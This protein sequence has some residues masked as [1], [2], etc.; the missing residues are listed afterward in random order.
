[1]SFTLKT[2]RVT[3][4]SVVMLVLI[5]TIVL[6]LFS[7]QQ[8]N[9]IEQ[10][11]FETA[12]KQILLLIK[13]R[14][15]IYKQ[16][17]LGGAGLFYGSD[18]VT[19]QD[20][21]SY[22]EE[23]NIDLLFPGIQGMGFSRVIK[24]EELEEH[25]KKIRAEGF[26]SYTIIPQGKRDLYTSIIYLE[27]FNS[28]NQRA[29]GFDMF[30]EPVRQE[31]MRRAI[32]T[33]E[34]SMSRKVR[35]LQE[36]GV[37]E[38]SGFLIYVPVYNKK[39]PLN[40]KEEKMQAIQG[41]VYAPFRSKDLMTGIA[42]NMVAD[43]D[44]EIYDN[45]I[46]DKSTLLFDS[47]AKHYEQEGDLKYTHI[48]EIGGR[49][50]TIQFTAMSSFHEQISNLTSWVILV[51]GIL[52]SIFFFSLLNSFIIMEIRQQQNL[53]ELQTISLRKNLALQTG[54]IGIWEWIYDSDTLVWDDMMYHIY[55]IT[56]KKTTL[57][58]YVWS[59]AIDVNE[60]H[61]VE[62][63]LVHARKHN[64]E[65]NT[66]FW[67]TT[68]TGKRKYIQSV[69]INEYNTHGNAYR[70]VGVNID[71]TKQKEFEIELLQAKE[72]A[73]LANRSKS[74]FVANMSHEIR[75]PMNG[76]IGLIRLVLDT[77]LKP[78]QKSYLRKI[79]DSSHALLNILND[80]LDYSKIEAGKLYLENA[81]FV[82]ETTLHE[83]AELFVPIA[84]EKGIEIFVDIDSNIPQSING[85]AFRLSQVLNNLIGNAIKFSRRGCINIIASKIINNGQ[86]Q[87]L[88]EIKDTGIGM[89]AEQI[90]KLF[91]AFTQADSSTTRKYGGTGLG[92]TIC[93]QLVDL[94]G[95]K[96]WVES[97]LNVGSSFIF[98]IPL[99][100][101]KDQTTKSNHLQLKTIR[102]T[103]VVDDQL[104]S[105]DIMEKMLNQMSFEVMTANSAQ[106]A[107]QLIEQEQQKEKPFEMFIIDWVMPEMDGLSLAKIIHQQNTANNN[108]A[109]IIIMVTANGKQK[110]LENASKIKL[111]AILEKPITSSNLLDTIVTL[112]NV[113]TDFNLN[114]IMNENDNC[115]EIETDVFSG[116]KVLLAED[117][118]TNQLVAEGFLNK[119]GLNV[120]T[121]ENGRA[122]VEM[123]KN[124][125]FDIVLMDLQMPIMGG[126]EATRK[127]REF[128]NKESLPIIAM[129]AAAMPQ[130][131]ES[132]FS[133]GMNDYISKPIDFY[134]LLL[135]LKKFL[136]TQAKG[137][138]PEHNAPIDICL[139]GFN[140]ERINGFLK[141]GL[142]TSN[143]ISILKNFETEYRDAKNELIK[144]KQQG[145]DSSVLRLIHAIKGSAGNIG[146][147][148]LYE[149]AKALEKN[150]KLGTWFLLEEF[151]VELD[152]T[153]SNILT[154]QLSTIANEQKQEFNIAEIKN[155]LLLIKQ[156][157]AKQEFISEE[158]AEQLNKFSHFFPSQEEFK[159]LIDSI[160]A[161]NYKTTLVIVES[162]LA[163]LS[164][165]INNNPICY[166]NNS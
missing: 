22:I 15:D 157:S 113:S 21:K 97:E 156:K 2:K 43:I 31:A 105:L 86:E 75:T 63:N 14:M 165:I 20:W 37:D 115:F 65:Y 114:K 164:K 152:K 82:L 142:S 72:Q 135:L 77:D 1:M 47:N 11:R 35:L 70:M 136:K 8:N 60:K 144:L 107:L 53:D 25:I 163:N 153:L 54:T 162:M 74:D 104:T 125:P 29:F 78:V 161:L 79:Y 119:V 36:N 39:M 13:N 59:N 32:E 166:K 42:G 81:D 48:L 26:P 108:P 95:G 98:Q 50:W 132:S 151:Y 126:L 122:A 94:M 99:V 67:I 130:D 19:R 124:Q 150:I 41:F 7:F 80:I 145:D 27:P 10:A 139:E 3:Q 34:P 159:Q 138:I 140:S 85:D 24:P 38:Q 116:A 109:P 117:N 111:N 96:L 84:E 4:Y 87:L 40:T 62:E 148:K 118:T 28:R 92:L 12:S 127:I 89:S 147:I 121:V 71:I 149:L 154:L 103:L 69:G 160:H 90:Q 91:K 66:K 6:S 51:S 120:T 83:S 18:V 129:T 16:V 64:V 123:V 49:K 131:K 88:F 106:R 44:V 133:V 100:V 61:S 57:P 101:A 55:G 17:L 45:E 76:I 56:E 33:G 134:E 46:I 52:L 23:Q 9:Q 137:N 143:V 30:S 73:E 5:L 158:E 155:V 58:Y 102:K 128:R 112:E 110:V 68:P 146:A 93:K 141:L